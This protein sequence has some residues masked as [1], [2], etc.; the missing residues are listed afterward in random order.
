MIATYIRLRLSP[1][2][3]HTFDRPLFHDYFVCNTLAGSADQFPF[4]ICRGQQLSVYHSRTMGCVCR[5]RKEARKSTNVNNMWKYHIHSPLGWL[6]AEISRPI[7]DVDCVYSTLS[8][9]LDYIQ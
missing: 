1:E 2:F 9:I 6:D 3:L 7:R 8:E 4:C 5:S